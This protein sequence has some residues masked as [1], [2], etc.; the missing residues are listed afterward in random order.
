MITCYALRRKVGLR[1]E[2]MVA[3]NGNRFPYEALNRLE[4]AALLLRHERDR[5]ARLARAR[6]PA[7]AVDIRLGLE[8]QR[9]IDDA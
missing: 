2:W 8:R 3:V 5:R 4:L 7:D 1:L 6:R 9:H